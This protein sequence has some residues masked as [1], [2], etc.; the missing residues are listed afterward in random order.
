MLPTEGVDF[1]G[2]R[3]G[4]MFAVPGGGFHSGQVA[5]STEKRISGVFPVAR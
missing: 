5:G 1:F 3:F 4:V 2:V